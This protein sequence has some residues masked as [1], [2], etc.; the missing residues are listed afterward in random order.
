M[1]RAFWLFGDKWRCG[2][3]SS[4]YTDE[5]LLKDS[6]LRELKPTS[7]RQH[8]N[9]F[10]WIWGRK[11]LDAGEYDFIYHSD[12]FVSIAGSTHQKK[13]AIDNLVDA[14]ISKWPSSSFQEVARTL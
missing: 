7:S 11:P 1:L 12:D 6:Q 14:Y 13:D 5:L 8:L 2:A 4:V 3:D 10:H 9:L